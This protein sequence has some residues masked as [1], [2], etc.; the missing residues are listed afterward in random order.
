MKVDSQDSGHRDQAVYNIRMH[1]V[2]I[3]FGVHLHICVVCIIVHIALNT[4]TDNM[5]T[6]DIV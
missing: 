4:R 3:W 1:I 6:N 2:V 5:V